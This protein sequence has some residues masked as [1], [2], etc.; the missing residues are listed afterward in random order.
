MPREKENDDPSRVGLFERFL[1]KLIGVG[2]TR[3]LLDRDRARGAIAKPNTLEKP[4]DVVRVRVRILQS[5]LALREAWIVV[6]DD[7]CPVLGRGRVRRNCDDPHAHKS[8]Q[9]Y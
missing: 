1:P 6:A 9:G 8:S 3:I 2:E 5:T 4:L 7:Q